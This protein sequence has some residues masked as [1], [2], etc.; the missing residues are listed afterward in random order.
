M[1]DADQLDYAAH[2]R[3]AGHTMAEIVTKTG[4]TRTSLYRHLPLR[5]PA[6]PTAKALH[7]TKPVSTSGRPRDPMA[8]LRPPPEHMPRMSVSGVGYTSVRR[9]V[10][11]VGTSTSPRSMLRPDRRFDSALVIG[12]VGADT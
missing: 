8:V 10:H 9:R 6:A 7:T 1:V 11:C 5:P 3:Y 12:L 4:I 2:L